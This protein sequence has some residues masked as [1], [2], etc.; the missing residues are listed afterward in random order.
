M[1]YRPDMHQRRPATQLL[2]L[3]VS[4][5]VTV[6]VA[7][8]CGDGGTPS[9]ES[10]G[11]SSE[12]V[13]D[14]SPCSLLTDEQRVSLIGVETPEASELDAGC[15]WTGPDGP[16]EFHVSLVMQPA[17]EWA[18]HRAA[19]DEVMREQDLTPPSDRKH[20][21]QIRRL[22]ESVDGSDVRGCSVFVALGELNGAP[23][24]SRTLTR[25]VPQFGD[26]PPGATVERC[27]D[28][29]YA[30]LSFGGPKMNETEAPRLATDLLDEIA[31]ISSTS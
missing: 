25:V 10:K 20:A 17:S 14:G 7:G 13:R 12:S 3:G 31:P 5:A 16:N 1:T 21:A 15:L 30:R 4:L 26:V 29:T 11:E 9:R 27:V 28:G 8:A 18:A 23:P 2:L 19:M 6:L 22:L 24:G